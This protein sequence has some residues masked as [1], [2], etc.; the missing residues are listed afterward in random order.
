MPGARPNG[1]FAKNAMNRQPR[2]DASAVATKTP[3]A[4]MPA[5]D[6]IDGLTARM[7]AM[8]MKVVIPAMISVFTS[9]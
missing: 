1:M 4:S 7:Y 3:A 5:T 6:R 2:Q 8:V 9:V